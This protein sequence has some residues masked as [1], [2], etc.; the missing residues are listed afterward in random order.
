MIIGSTRPIAS[1]ATRPLGGAASLPAY[2]LSAVS[3]DTGFLIANQI[4]Y[5]DASLNDEISQAF[6]VP[7]T[8]GAR[9]FLN[10]GTAFDDFNIANVG[11]TYADIGFGFDF[12][13]GGRVNGD[14]AVAWPIDA[15]PGAAVKNPRFLFRLSV[16]A[17]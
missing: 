15:D 1:F 17:F 2:E 9:A 13:I 16:N 12:D 7:V 6:K 11:T 3:G 4:R 10:F 8:V 5:T 14:L